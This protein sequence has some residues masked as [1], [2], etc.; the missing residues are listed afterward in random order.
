MKYTMVKCDDCGKERKDYDAKGWL[1]VDEL[2]PPSAHYRDFSISI[3]PY[4]SLPTRK[5]FCGPECLLKYAQG[6][7]EKAQRGGAA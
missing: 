2:L 4:G 3:V 7:V 1:F 5:E 6:L